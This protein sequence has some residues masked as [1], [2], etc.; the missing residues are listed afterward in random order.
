MGRLP[1]DPVRLPGGM[2]P[3]SPDTRT[4]IEGLDRVIEAL[5]A[6]DVEAVLGLIEWGE[7]ACSNHGQGFPRQAQC[8]EGA[9]DGTL[10]RSVPFSRNG[11]GARPSPDEVRAALEEAFAGEPQLCWITERL[12]WDGEP[13]YGVKMRTVTMSGEFYLGMDLVV[14]VDA[15]GR[16]PSLGIG[17]EPST[18]I[19]V[20]H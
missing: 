3:L 14:R 15:Q 12:R 5:V 20:C 13:E 17:P 2:E 11:E 6:Y 4:G 8:P 18:T 9:P 10:V 19:P 7:F 1:A 16:M